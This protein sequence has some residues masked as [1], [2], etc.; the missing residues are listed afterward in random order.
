MNNSCDSEDL[1]GIMAGQYLGI[2]EPEN[3]AATV[4]FLLSK[5]AKFITGSSVAVDSGRLSS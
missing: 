1:R 5:E 2:C 4:G 3:I